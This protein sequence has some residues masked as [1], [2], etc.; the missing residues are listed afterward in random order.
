M[1]GSIGSLTNSWLILL[2]A[3][4][5]D[6]T[7]LALAGLKRLKMDSIIASSES[8]AWDVMLP[9]VAQGS[10]GLQCRSDDAK[11]LEYVKALNHPSSTVCVECERSFLRSLD[12]NCRTP[13]AGQ[14][15]IT[16]GKLHF[17]GLICKPDGKDLK[18]VTKVGRI[19]DAVSI[20][21][22][23]GEQ[24]RAAVGGRLSDYGIGK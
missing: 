16:D 8:I 10:I 24:I 12:G 6:A 21:V 5:V 11:N 2:L 4:I 19:E 20:G 23:A 22:E 18:R 1:V 15:K 17:E 7:L 14:A 3:G 13:I 9:A